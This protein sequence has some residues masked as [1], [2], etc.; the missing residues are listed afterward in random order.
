MNGEIVIR[1]RDLRFAYPARL[2][3]PAPFALHI[4]AWEVRRGERIALHGPSGS[5][6]S[7]LLDLV[8]GTLRP[9]AGALEVAGRDLATLDERASRE[10][11][12]RHIGFVFQDYPLVEHLSALENVTLPFRLNHALVLDRSARERARAL[13]DELGIGNKTHRLPSQ[14]SQGERQRIAIAR[15]LVT[16]PELLLADEPTAGLD[17]DRAQGVLDLLL[18]SSRERRLTLIVVTHDPRVLARLDRRVA[19]GDLCRAEAA[20]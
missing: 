18:A 1:A 2:H 13:L 14:L 15:A 12:I 5:G 11:R 10:H 16:N 4:A 7:T 3:E 19:I 9:Q 20:P 6:K 8:A 17:D